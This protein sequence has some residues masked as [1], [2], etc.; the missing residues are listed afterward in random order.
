MY[1]YCNLQYKVSLL[2]MRLVFFLIRKGL[3]M[4]IGIFM[5]AIYSGFRLHCFCGNLVLRFGSHKPN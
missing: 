5:F 1:H 2:L 3:F 4:S